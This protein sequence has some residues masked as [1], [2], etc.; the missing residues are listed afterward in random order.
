MCVNINQINNKLYG[1][2][3]SFVVHQDNNNEENKGSRDKKVLFLMAGPL[4]GGGGLKG[5]YSIFFLHFVAI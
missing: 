4:N 1:E 5:Q 2:T 3:I